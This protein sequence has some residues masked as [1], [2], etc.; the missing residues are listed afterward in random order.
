VLKNALNRDDLSIHTTLPDVQSYAPDIDTFRRQQNILVAYGD[1]ATDVLTFRNLLGYIEIPLTGHETVQRLQLYGNQNETLAGSVEIHADLTLSACKGNTT[2][3]TLDCGEGVALG[4]TPTS[5]FVALPAGSYPKGITVLATLTNGLRFVYRHTSAII[6]ARNERITLPSVTCKGREIHPFNEIRYTTSDEKALDFD[7]NRE[8]TNA[9][10]LSNSYE[11]GKGVLR[12]DEDVTTIER[13][14][15]NGCTSLTSVVIP[16]SVTEI[17][18]SA[19]ADLDIPQSITIPDSATWIRD[20]FRLCFSR[21]TSLESFCGKYATNDHRCLIVTGKLV[22]FAPSGLTSYQI[23]DS[24]TEIGRGAFCDCTSLKSIILPDSVTTI[25]RCAFRGCKSLKSITI[26]DSV[27]SIG[28]DAFEGCTSLKSITIS[29]SVITIGY[30]AFEDC[31]SLKS[32][33]LPDS[34]TTIG[35]SAFARCTNLKS[36][37]ISNS[38]ITIGYK[39]FDGCTGLKSIVIPDSVTTIGEWAFYGCTRLKSITIPDSVTTI[40]EWAF[41]NCTSL[42]SFCSKYATNDHRCLIDVADNSILIAFAPSGLTSYKISDSVTT[43]GDHAFAYCTRLQ[44]VIIPDSVTSIGDGAFWRC[45]SLASITLPDSVTSIGGSAFWDCTSLKSVTLPNGIT[46]IGY[47]AFGGCTSLTSIT[48][49]N[50]VT[51]IGNYAFEGCTSLTSITLPDSVTEI[52]DDAFEG[53]TSLDS[54]YGKY[55][56]ADHKQLVI[57]RRVVAM[58]RK[59]SLVDDLVSILRGFWR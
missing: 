54:F 30:E 40:G 43:I 46:E 21:C 12:F 9:R 3:L 31:T 37:T 44:S 36:I 51:E 5:F 58:A 20:S 8:L 17:G 16:D 41:G 28:D 47:R 26:P 7:E 24:V 13:R 42:E 27:T 55:A 49:P 52:G 2:S 53:C 29:N 23:P 56:T 15:F 34:V 19:F 11:Q 10:L 38:V 50:R 35:R 45:T 22:A 32:I 14:A 4:D 18:Y 57:G 59:R 1:N 39:A 6:L 33:I 25:E 48:I